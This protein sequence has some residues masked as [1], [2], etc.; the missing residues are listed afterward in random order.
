[1]PTPTIFNKTMTDAATEYSQAL[2]TRCR[3]CLVKERSGAS[4]VQLAYNSGESGTL[5]ITIPAGSGGK[6]VEVA[7]LGVRTL[8]FQCP[9]ANKILEIECW[10]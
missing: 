6:Y 1:M 4:L 3:K 8:Y 7:E 5:Y 9:D 2:P 10:V